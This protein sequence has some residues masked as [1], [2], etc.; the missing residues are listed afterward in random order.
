MDRLQSVMVQSGVCSINSSLTEIL[1]KQNTTLIYELISLKNNK[2][3]IF[4]ALSDPV[5]WYIAA[6]LLQRAT[7]EI[8]N[9]VLP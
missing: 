6:P 4:N 9:V 1:T 5:P 7:C 2:T 3:T 8:S